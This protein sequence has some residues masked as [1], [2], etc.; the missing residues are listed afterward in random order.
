MKWRVFQIKIFK[1]L[2]YLSNW[3]KQ[4][5][6]INFKSFLKWTLVQ[7]QNCR[8]LKRK[9]LLCSNIFKLLNKKWRKNWIWTRIWLLCKFIK[10][11]NLTLKLSLKR[12]SGR[13]KSWRSWNSK[14]LLY[15]NFSKHRSKFWRKFKAKL[16]QLSFSL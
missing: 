8:V 2:K 13:N 4:V 16:V 11:S 12:K 3:N 14:Q 15:S 1:C 5:L 7:N 10:N 6:K 9:Q